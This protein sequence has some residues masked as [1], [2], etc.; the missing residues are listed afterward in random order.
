MQVWKSSVGA[1]FYHLSFF[2]PVNMQVWIFFCSLYG[3]TCLR[4]STTLA[5]FSPANMQ[6][7]MLL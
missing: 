4:S 6:V 7:W 2:S 3:K 5:F 1:V